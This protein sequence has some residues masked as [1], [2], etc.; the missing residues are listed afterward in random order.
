MVGEGHA[1]ID[2][3]VLVDGVVDQEGALVEVAGA[4]GA[5]PCAA[6]VAE[7]WAVSVVPAQVLAAMLVPA[8]TPVA[9][10]R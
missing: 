2:V 4:I 1:A 10:L 3:E 5:D 9:V 7:R 6:K 8:T